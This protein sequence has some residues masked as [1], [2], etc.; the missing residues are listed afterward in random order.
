MG[1]E[2]AGYLR[3]KGRAAPRKDPRPPLPREERHALHKLR[4]EAKAAGSRLHSA[5]MGGLPPS[6]ILHVF[7]R[8]AYTC[9]VC[10]LLGSR[11]NGGLTA[12]HKGGIP[13]SAWLRKKGHAN[14]PA[15][16]VSICNSCHDRI[17]QEAE[18]AG[19]TDPDA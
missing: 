11:D 1:A 12:H 2:L 16:L 15:N 3:T 7:R 4:R 6:L 14:E 19:I 18:A 10:G 13:E 5:G 17:H 8:D 9:K